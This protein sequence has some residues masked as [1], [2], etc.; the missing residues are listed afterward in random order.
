MIGRQGGG[1]SRGKR[2]MK[3]LARIAALS[4]SLALVAQASAQ[5]TDPAAP[6]PTP[7][8][9]VAPAPAAQP[10]PTAVA[11]PPPPPP[12][13][14][15]TTVY[16]AQP[17]PTYSSR[18]A[19]SGPRAQLSGYLGVP[20]FVSDEHDVASAGVS[21]AGRYGFQVNGYVVPQIGGGWQ[22][23]WVDINNH[24]D[25]SSV[26]YNNRS[27]SMLYFNLGVRFQ[28]PNESKLIPF[29]SVNLDFNFWHLEGDSSISCGGYYYWWCG[30]YNNYHYEPGMSGRV[31]AMIKLNSGMALELGVRVATSF[32]TNVFASPETWLDPYIG[33]TGFM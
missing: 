31:G 13:Q 26:P 33:F 27:F 16:Y 2:F 8:A 11:P 6:P 18:P 14:S 24:P 12:S 30:S 17:Q 23:Q 15:N 20:V 29:A 28:V 9:G 21:L 19:S 22:I 5:Y 10:A 25:Y 7:P 4:L 32:G 1:S 3:N